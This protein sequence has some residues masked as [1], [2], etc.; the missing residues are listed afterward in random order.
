MK[1]ST[2][3]SLL[4]LAL[5]TAKGSPTPTAEKRAST[6]DV[7]N[8]GYCTQNGGT[9]GGS[10]GATT[11]VSSLAQLT[12]AASGTASAV[13]IVKGA[14]SGSAQ[15]RVGSNKSI[16][17]A[18]DSSLT[19]IGFYVKDQSNVIL[20]N[21][22]IGKVLAEN[23]DAIG[24]QNS[25]NVWVDHCDLSSDLS[26]DK[27]YYDGLC[28]VTHA[29]E[30]VTISNTYFHDHWKASLVGH[31]DSNSKEDTGHL[32]VTYANNYWSN[33]NSR[34]P[35]FRF[36]TGH[37]FNNYFYKL[38]DSGINTRM[39]AQLLVQSSVF[40]AS[41]TKA[42]ESA[43]SDTTGYATVSDVNLGGSTN[44]APSGSLTSVPYTYSLLGSANVKSSVTTNAGQKLSF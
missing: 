20:R 16:I 38:G 39:G 23:G 3:A 8:V 12:A 2:A 36:G 10:G 21:L 7:C 18:S 29:S 44:T 28:D 35:S 6:G 24:I 14:I 9:K 1:I 37:I 26:H 30:W 17:G 19:G 40:E 15:V 43:D 41:A 32:H 25:K 33:I 13:I 34:T 5:S 27:D 42:I 22:K 31:S 4:A 11:T